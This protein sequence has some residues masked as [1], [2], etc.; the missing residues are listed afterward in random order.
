METATM[1]I[2]LWKEF[3]GKIFW[4]GSGGFFRVF[5]GLFEGCFG[6]RGG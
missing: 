5:A 6:K 2:Q 3:K 4:S 1:P